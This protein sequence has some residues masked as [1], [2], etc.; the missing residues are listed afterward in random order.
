MTTYRVRM[1]DGTIF[2]CED[3]AFDRVRFEREFGIPWST[4]AFKA[5]QNEMHLEH[6]FWLAFVAWQ[7]QTGSADITF[8]EWGD[9]VADVD[10]VA[11]E[12][13]GESPPLGH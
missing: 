2:E 3:R 8:D 5:S 6:L 12:E 10:V 9:M 1:I 7:R 4:L 11:P 13:E